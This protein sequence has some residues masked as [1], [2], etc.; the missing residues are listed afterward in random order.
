MMSETII[1]GFLAAACSTSAF[2]PQVIKTWR[3]HSTRDISVGTFSAIVLGAVLWMVYAWLQRDLPVFATN[4]VRKALS[5]AGMS[6]LKSEMLRTIRISENSAE[7]CDA[8]FLRIRPVAPAR[9]PARVWCRQPW[10]PRGAS[11]SST[12]RS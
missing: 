4:G 2:V 10:S 8:R 5:Q 9:A 7:S 1:L 6:G 11:S 12:R 3:T